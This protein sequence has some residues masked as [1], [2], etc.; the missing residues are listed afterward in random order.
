MIQLT[1]LVTIFIIF[2]RTFTTSVLTTIDPKHELLTEIVGRYRIAARNLRESESTI[3]FKIQF[4]IHDILKVDGST[5]EYIFRATI[6]I[7]YQFEFLHWDFNDTKNR[8]YDINEIVLTKTM[9]QTLWLPDIHLKDEEFLSFKIEHESAKITR[10]G[11]IIW[12]RRGL[13]TI[14]SLIDL[15]YYPFDHQ[16]IRI[17]MFNKQNS[18]RLE[19][20]KKNI[21]KFHSIV[22]RS[23]NLWTRLFGSL[24]TNSA[25]NHSLIFQESDQLMKPVLLRGWFVRTLGVESKP[26]SENLNSLSIYILMQRRRESHIYTTILPTLFFSVFIIIFYFSS[27][28]SYQ[29]LMIGL[30]HIFATLLFMIHLDKKISA[31]QLSY[32]PLILR[33]LSL[34]FLI[35]I[36]SLFFDHIIHS[37]YFGGIHFVTDWLRKKDKYESQPAR[38]S[39]VRLLTQGLQ[40]NNTDNDEG[41]NIFMK[42]LIEREE[43]L[44]FEDYQQYQWH[45]QACLSECLCCSF[46]L[47]IIIVVFLF[48]FFIVPTFGFY[49]K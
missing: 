39:H 22:S 10:D 35:E 4:P 8:Y 13:F 19:Y 15:T 40:L 11:Y 36:L 37:I 25:G 29:R 45:Q 43:S 38:L 32:T 48:I 47:I 24:E 30:L 1:V 26:D 17:N 31:E 21:S 49:Q 14:L 44:K 18:F 12:I 42:Q 46:F 3:P 2:L 23:F 6:E 20:E 33:Y 28:K 34:I 16:Y 5:N 7:N 27:I 41:T 9:L